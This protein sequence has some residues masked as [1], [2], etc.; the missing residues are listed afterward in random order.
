VKRKI[1]ILDAMRDE[2]LFGPWFSGESWKAWRVFL[3]ALFGA[4]LEGEA[5]ET[6]RK[7][8]ARTD[9]PTSQ[10]GECFCICGRRSGK[11]LIAAMIALFLSCFRDYSNVLVPGEMGVVMLVAS[12]RRQAR[13]LLGY[14]NGFFDSIP[15]LRN[16]VAERLKESI[17]LTNRIRI[18][19]HTSSFRAVR[20]YTI[21]GAI[22]DEI[23]FWPTEDSANP[24]T[25]IL[26]ALRPAMATVPN[27][28]LLAISSPYARRGVLWET[29][30]NNFGKNDAPVLVWQAETRAMNPTLPQRVIDEAFERD[31]VSAEAEYR[32]NFRTDCE[33]LV[34]LE[35]INAC[36]PKGYAE[37]P[38]TEKTRYV[39]FVDPSGGSS[40][41]MTLGIAHCNEVGIAVLDVLREARPPFSPERVV[42]DFANDLRRYRISEVFGD[43]YAGEWPRERFSARGITYRV[44]E[45]SRSQIYLEFLAL[46]NSKRASLLENKRLTA[47]IAGLER[48]V[49]RSGTETIDHAPGGRDDCSNAAAGALVLATKAQ[50]DSEFHSFIAFADGRIWRPSVAAPRVSVTEKP[51]PQPPQP[52]PGTD[53]ALRLDLR[54]DQ[55]YR[56]LDDEI[57]RI[58]K[59]LNRSGNVDR[60]AL[61]AQHCELCQ[62]REELCAKLLARE[63]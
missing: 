22:C 38:P 49:S 39:A 8:T 5:L 6:Y 51:K 29:H 27:A 50:R 57:E 28:L 12:D 46:L 62:R 59:E 9:A 43:A 56:A 13:V 23:A 52:R 40:D 53:A 55:K 25:E 60:S 32:A 54:L 42:A 41:S 16:M 14:I 35:I 61:K 20:G 1:S 17:A 58:E 18:E 37:F 47:Q 31:P 48:H 15:M 7:Y 21:V 30:R 3:G 10:F 24:D 33:R 34:G 26:N 11:S 36:T 63:K 19:I 45:R 2:R 44:S 4:P